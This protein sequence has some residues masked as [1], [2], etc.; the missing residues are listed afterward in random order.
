MAVAAASVPATAHAYP[1]DPGP[2]IWQAEYSVEGPGGGQALVTDATVRTLDCKTILVEEQRTDRASRFYR[3]ENRFPAPN[4][5]LV[6]PRTEGAQVVVPAAQ[7]GWNTVYGWTSGVG[8]LDWQ[9][10]VWV[11]SCDDDTNPLT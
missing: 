8:A 9:R 11:P 4:Q 7:Y 2:E 5:Y 3:A 1:G 6:Y 10:V